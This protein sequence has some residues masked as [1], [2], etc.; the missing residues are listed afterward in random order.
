MGFFLCFEIIMHLIKYEAARTALAEA[1]RIDEVKDIRDKAEALRAYARQAGDI[2]MVNWAA[3]IKVRAERKAGELLIEMKDNG[4]R[5]GK[6]RIENQMYRGGTFKLHDME[7]NRNQSSRYQQIARIPET[8]FEAKIANAKESGKEI[9]SVGMRKLGIMRKAE[10][11]IDTIVTPGF[12]D[13]P[14][15]CIVIDPPWPI[16]KIMMDR[17]PS[18]KSEMDYAT[19]SLDK[20]TE[21]P[22]NRLAAP[23]GTHV[24]LWVTHKFLPTG[25]A[26]FESWGIRYECVLTWIK[27]TAQPLWWRNL[28][29]HVL[30]GKIGSLAPLVKGS[31]TCFN[32]PQQRH[33]HK[34]TEFFDMANKISP[35]PR[36]TMFD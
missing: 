26:L 18:E 28:T 23:D 4:E 19:M 32:A 5:H 1:H 29:E 34:P 13:G 2:E 14:F 8:A 31:P 17:R 35:E 16:E 11:Q 3:E 15:R 6:G 20:I 24:Y 25:L 30:F 27:P 33:S 7:L 22:I 9:T 12:P 36:L 10:M 21:L